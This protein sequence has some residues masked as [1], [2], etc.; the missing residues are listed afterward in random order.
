MSSVEW[1]R[2]PTV[3][4][5][6]VKRLTEAKGR[7]GERLEP[8]ERV[9]L[10]VGLLR[11]VLSALARGGVAECLVVSPDPVALAV[12]ATAGATPLRQEGDGLNPALELARASRPW[13]PLLVTLGDL[14]LLRADEVAAILRLAAEPAVV[15]A[16]DR[17]ERGTNL[18][19]LPPDVTLPFQFGRDSLQRHLALARASGRPVRLF[20]SPGTALDLDTPAD[21]DEIRRL[22]WPFFGDLWPHSRTGVAMIGETT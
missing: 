11:S 19:A 22:G 14:P 7:L 15:A 5:V 12:A 21:L 13:R 2:R 17:E 8:D 3:A 20:R 16:P 4:I 10:V 1:P 6:P 9:A 18:L